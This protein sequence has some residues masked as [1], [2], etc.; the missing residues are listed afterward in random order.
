M[1]F[2]LAPLLLAMLLTPWRRYYRSRWF[3]MGAL[4]ALLLVLPNVLWQAHA[5]FRL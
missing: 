4:L 3:R 5:H 2:L 1:A